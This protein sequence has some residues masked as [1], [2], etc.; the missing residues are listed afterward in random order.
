MSTSPASPGRGTNGRVLVIDDAPA[1][2]ELI[3][4]WLKQNACQYVFVE[5]EEQGRTLLARHHFD[6]VLYSHEFEFPR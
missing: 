5:D 2:K 6:A 3:V 1:R 4:R